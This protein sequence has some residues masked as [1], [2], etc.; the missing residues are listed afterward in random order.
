MNS[1]ELRKMPPFLFILA[2][3]AFLVARS[4]SPDDEAQQDFADA[5]S[6][7]VYPVQDIAVTETIIIPGTTQSAESALLRFQ[8]SGRVL[9]KNTRLGNKI[10]KGE[11]LASLYNPEIQPQAARATENLQQLDVQL[12]QAKRDFD[13]INDLYKEQAVTKQEWE[14]VKT[15][16]KSAQRAVNAAQAEL[17][18]ANRLA[19]E[20]KLVAPF[21]GVV[22]EIMIDQGEVIQTG[23]PAIRLS[24]PGLVE[25]TLSVSDQ[26]IPK[27]TQGQI[28]RVVPAL[29]NTAQTIDGLVSEISPFREQGSLP[30]III[31]LPADQIQ[32]GVAVSARIDI[33]GD[34]GLNIPLKAVVM[35][36]NDSTAVYVIKE[37]RARLLPIRP[38]RI[39]N[40]SVLVESTL[41]V[42]DQIVI[43]GISQ[44]YD[45]ANV[46]IKSKKDAPSLGLAPLSSDARSDEV[47]VLNASSP[48]LQL[49]G[50][51]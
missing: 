39:G 5:V 7:N 14:Q 38:I 41:E 15:T 13:R 2:M 43:A 34:S 11:V 4:L 16:R 29:D 47:Q 26:V 35:T 9:E 46:H 44:L 48:S 6:V 3:F 51:E 30:Q 21:D 10:R 36:G 27:L 45:G 17:Q 28:V 12:S 42:G 49:G 1:L 33:A 20:L 37:G 50:A 18:R 23:S 25:L 32:P 40:S 22:T 31:S 24:N 19:E 8:V